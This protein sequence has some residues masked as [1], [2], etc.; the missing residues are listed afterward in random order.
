V[1][2]HRAVVAVMAAM[3]AVVDQPR[4]T[5]CQQPGVIYYWCSSADNR[6]QSPTT[7]LPSAIA[8]RTTKKMHHHTST[9]ADFKNGMPSP[10]PAITASDITI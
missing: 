10:S 4:D 1:G 6:F 3:A 5:T 8:P 7:P 2:G 9:P